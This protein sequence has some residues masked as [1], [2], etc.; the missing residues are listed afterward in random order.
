[1]KLVDTRDLKSLASN[2]VPVQVRLRVPY[3]ST[4][5]P[6]RHKRL[7]FFVRV[8]IYK[9]SE[10]YFIL[11]IAYIGIVYLEDD[12]PTITLDKNDHGL[13]YSYLSCLKHLI[14][15]LAIR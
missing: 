5:W 6:K 1:M 10:A 7:G 3:S 13:D 12:E 11:L 14:V 4:D 9:L 2:S 8:Y 15:S